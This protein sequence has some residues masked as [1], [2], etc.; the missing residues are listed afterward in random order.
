MASPLASRLETYT[1]LAQDDRDATG[2]RPVHVN[3][4]IHEMRRDRPVEVDGKRLLIPD[5]ERL[6]EAG[7]FNPNYL[8]LDREGR[9]LDSN[10]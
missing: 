7:Q 4:T 5:L 1:R 6:M 9:R 3:R 2:L 10:D 8:H